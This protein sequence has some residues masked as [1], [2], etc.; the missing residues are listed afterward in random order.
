M[1]L[2]PALRSFCPPFVAGCALLA[3]VGL[4]RAAPLTPVRLAADD[5]VFVPTLTESLG[6]FQ[7]EGLAI[8]PVKVESFEK[9]DYLLQR[10]LDRGQI[11]AVYHWFQHAVI[12]A[13][14][15]LP[16]KA[17]MLFNDAPGITILVANRVKDQVRSAADFAG[18]PI[19]QGAGYGTKGV[20]TAWLAAKAGLP[21]GS[22]TPVLT[23]TVGRQEAVIKGLRDGAVDVMTF[24]E[25]I[26]SALEDTHLVSTL[27]D[28]NSGPSTARVLGAPFPSQCLLMAPKFIAAHPDTVQRLVNAFVRTMRFVNTHT[29]DEI[30]AK[31]PADFFAGQDRAEAIRLLRSTLSTF[32]QGDYSIPPAGARLTVEIIQ[33]SRFDDSEEG[34]WRRETVHASVDPAQLYTNEFVT[35]AMR[36]IPAPARA[37]EPLNAGVSIWT[38]NVTQFRKEHGSVGGYTKRWDLSGLP[39][40][41]PRQ[42]VSGTLRVWG[43]NYIKDGYLADYWEEAFRRFQPGLKLDYHLPT[44]GIAIP[45]LSCGVADVAMSRKAI[46][47]DLLTF[48]QVYHHP[49]TEISAVTG[50]Y[51]VYGWAPAFIIAVNRNNPL[52]QITM[53][54]LDGVFGGARLGGYVGSVWHS[55]YPYARGPEENIRTWGQLGLTG[56]WADKP[57]HTG[58]Q[59]M[60]GNATTGFSDLVIRGSDQFTEGY[61]SYANYIM[62]DGKVNSWSLQARRAIAQDPYAMFYVSPASMGPELKE[63]AIQAQD[64]GPYVPRSLESVHDRSYPLINQYYFYLNR[65]PGRPVDPKVDEFIHFIL[66]QEG[67]DC[68]QREGRYIPLTAEVVRAQ[69]KKI[70]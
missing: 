26:T 27:Y 28:L 67:Q 20:L 5:G 34:R 42:Q 48:E 31:L 62:P 38:Q 45:A 49:V 60:R 54:Q 35:R 58:G 18:R 12:G 9:E 21:P 22:Y 14:H 63:L 64:G 69:L 44:T 43:N 11:D 55:E 59:S 2:I 29:A 25:P 61:R 70:E 15:D 30:A 6:Y 10:P 24:Q 1:K 68:V 51:D 65:E 57:I 46:I 47:M 52:T 37:A 7:A 56:E 19:A 39:H 16:V 36:A 17:V 40:Y 33:S 53:K 4:V 23:E 41:V 13:R 50:S 3:P 8:V 32:A 66:S